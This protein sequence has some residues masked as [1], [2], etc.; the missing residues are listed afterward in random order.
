MNLKNTRIY[1]NIISV[2]CGFF[3]FKICYFISGIRFQ[4]FIS[5]LLLVRKYF[6]LVCRCVKIFTTLLWLTL[7]S[8]LIILILFNIKEIKKIKSCFKNFE[9][10]KQSLNVI[11]IL[12]Q[13]LARSIHLGL[14]SRDLNRLCFLVQRRM[15]I[16]DFRRTYLL[17]FFLSQ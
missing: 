8:H 2:T 9:A 5:E 17:F 16:L 1:I 7:C 13:Q 6:I 14:W 15:W 4:I 11:T 12:K 3:T 10:Y